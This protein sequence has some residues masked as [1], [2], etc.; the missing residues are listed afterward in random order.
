VIR[1]LHLINDLDTGGAEMML[2]KL[3]SRFDRRRFEAEVVSLTDVGPI[4]RLI[5]PLGVRVRGLGMK[6]GVPDPRALLRLA[7]WIR[8]ASPHVVQTWMYHADLVGGLAA[9]MARRG[10]IA[11]GL[12]QTNLERAYNKRTSIWTAQ[13]CAHLS[14]SVPARIVCCSE[15]TRKLHAGLGYASAKM[16][17]IPNGF[18]L[19]AFRP[20]EDAR[21][22]VRAELAI[23]EGAKVVGLVGR[24]DAQKDHRNF[25]EAAARVHAS[26]PEARFVLCGDGIDR[27]NATLAA[28]I[29]TAEIGPV[30]HLLGRRTDVARLTAAFDVAALS[31]YTEGFPN[32]VGEAMA[33]A[34]PCAVTDAGDAADLVGQT[35]RVAPPKDPAALAGALSSLLSLDPAARAELGRAARARVA[36]H[37]SL[38]AIA[39]RYDSL[40][41]ELAGSA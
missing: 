3:V 15:A 32:V 35:G 5:E 29:D 28:W 19:D 40:Y 38:A 9:R 37:F 41:E 22:D 6:R 21:R 39:A 4:G 36:E 30:T 1:V 31:S 33:C 25:V 34:V 13:A 24:F 27:S 10:R 2:F 8:R 16:V 12:R 26:H 17:V 11:W 18:D 23:P 7:G 14:R 20:D